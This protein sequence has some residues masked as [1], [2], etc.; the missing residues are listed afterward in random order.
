[1]PMEPPVVIPVLDPACTQD[2]GRHGH[3]SKREIAIHRNNSFSTRGGVAPCASAFAS[4]A[5]RS[6]AAI[7]IRYETSAVT[8]RCHSR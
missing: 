1:L 4:I 5:L 2:A 3:K 6:S 8:R 7:A